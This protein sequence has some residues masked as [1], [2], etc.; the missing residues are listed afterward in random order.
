MI[1]INKLLPLIASPICI[2][3]T[4]LAY[5]SL[6]GSKK[7]S[8]FT[9]VILYIICTPI[10]SNVIFRL[11]EGNA[12]K[13][14]PNL[15]D[16]SDAIVILSG[17]IK[18]VTTTDGISYEWE[19]PDRFFGGIELYRLKKAH[20]L[21]F[22]GGKLPW[23]LDLK[24]EGQILKDY[25]IDMGVNPNDI[26]VT[27]DVQNTYQEALAIRELLGTTNSRIILVTSAFHMRRA[28]YIF[29]SLN[30][31]ILTF[32]VDFKSSNSIITPM[33]FLPQESGLAMTSSAFREFIGYLYYKVRNIIGFGSIFNT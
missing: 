26:I 19:D 21:I 28:K 20:K 23:R 5:S 11:V 6:T 17:M 8:I 27:K 12:I 22:T 30:I 4:S 29:E 7:L 32:A 14:D 3:I 24:T 18:A 10:T 33:D 25:A 15:I 2:I 1:Y 31:P 13:Q 9:I 16:T